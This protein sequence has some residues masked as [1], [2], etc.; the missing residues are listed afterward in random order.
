MTW[1]QRR[2]AS[3]DRYHAGHQEHYIGDN[4]NRRE[5]GLV[6]FDSTLVDDLPDAHPR[7]RN[8]RQTNSSRETLVTQGII[9]LETD[10]KL[11][12]LKEVAL[13]L[14]EGVVEQLLDVRTHSGYCSSRTVSANAV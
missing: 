5:F 9:I 11:D 8:L 7:P 2:G 3:R 12:C 1:R 10:L 4:V 6:T 14:V 13:L